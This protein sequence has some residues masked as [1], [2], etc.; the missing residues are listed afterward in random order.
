VT[1]AGYAA[2]AASMRRVAGE[3]GAPVGAVL[4]GGY[5]LG[6][7]ARSVA[8]TM[9]ALAGGPEGAAFAPSAAG[10]SSLAR[11]AAARVAERWPGLA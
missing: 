4:E 3:L 9:E 8:A 10:I 6:A 7:L 5:A 2:M 11:D 1:E